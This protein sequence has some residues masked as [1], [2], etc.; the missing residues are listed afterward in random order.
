MKQNPEFRLSVCS[1]KKCVRYSD[2][3]CNEGKCVARISELI[4]PSTFMFLHAYCIYAYI[5]IYCI[6]TRGDRLFCSLSN[7]MEYCQMCFLIKFA[8]INNFIFIYELNLKFLWF[9][10]EWLLSVRLFSIPFERKQISIS[11]NNGARQ[12]NCRNYT[13]AYPKNW[14]TNIWIFIFI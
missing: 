11:M 6:F 5:H 8:C 13:V 9:I 12:L 14:E 10:I 7:W 3:K 1:R 2:P 4:S